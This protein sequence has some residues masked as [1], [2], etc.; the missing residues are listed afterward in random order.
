MNYADL[1]H[2]LISITALATIVLTLHKVKKIHLATYE[3]TS[4]ANETEKIFEQLQSLYA[5]ERT[6][7]LEKP[8]PK[9]R[10][11]AGSPDFLLRT[12]TEVLSRKPEVVMECSSGA[13]T[14][15]IARCLQLNGHGHVYS[16][17]HDLAYSKKTIDLISSHG[18]SSW[19]TVIHAPLETKRTDT[20][21]YS[22]DLIPPDL[23]KIDVLVVDGPPSTTAP[24]AR[25]PALP[26]LI[27][28]KS[29]NAIIIADDTSRS[30][31][32]RMIEIW[33]KNFQI[34]S[35]TDCDCEKGCTLLELNRP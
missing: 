31:D 14:V 16:L 24:M 25:L 2:L 20:P 13:S 27:D 11:W 21:W 29:K 30:D 17:E 4:A 8:L 12:A 9:L 28:R 1:F 26:R 15:V 22:E 3:L 6:L 19:A 23:P 18:L 7:H 33:M 34:N 35:I 10:G 5:L 32:S